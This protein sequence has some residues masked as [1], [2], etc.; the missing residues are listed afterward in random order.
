MMEALSL[1]LRYGSA[2]LEQ[3]HGPTALTSITRRKTSTGMSARVQEAASVRPVSWMPALLC[4]TSM[5]PNASAAA[6]I[7]A[8]AWP[9]SVT[10]QWQ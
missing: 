7:R 6:A 8:S 1:S 2:Y 9:G 5:P 10:S 3:I 4:S